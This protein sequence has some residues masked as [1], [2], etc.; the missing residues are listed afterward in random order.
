MD[1]GLRYEGEA[2]RQR[3]I[4]LWLRPAIAA[5]AFGLFTFFV[6]SVPAEKEKI[7]LRADVQ[8]L[9][10]ENET[11]QGKLRDMLPFANAGRSPGLYTAQLGTPGDDGG[12]GRVLY[13]EASG[14]GV[15]YVAG[16]TTTD[17]LAFCWWQDAEGTRHPLAMIELID[18][19]GEASIQLRQER[20]GAVLV[21]LGSP[22]AEPDPE[23]TPIFEAAIY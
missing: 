9:T 5:L 17:E 8:R 1:T 2:A 19:S 10:A 22:G 11:L 21:T 20:E 12:W 3:F 14:R 15:V 7:Q 6:V 16:L 4:V 18:G 23:A 13:D